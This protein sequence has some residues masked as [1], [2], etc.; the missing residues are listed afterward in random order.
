MPSRTTR[1]PIRAV[2][3]LTGLPV[4]TLRAWE[5]R[6]GAVVPERGERGRVY[7]A[8][9]V[10]RLQLIAS[11]V[12]RGHAIGSIASLPDAELRR[13]A[14]AAA[15]DTPAPSGVDLA[16]L[17][18]AV[19]Q[20]DLPVL[21]SELSRHSLLL[22]PEPLIFGV[23]LP[24]LRELGQRWEAGSINPAQEHLVSA[25]VRGMLGGLL[26]SMPRRA[27]APIVFAAPAGERHE[28]GLLCAAVLA[29][30]S[31]YAPI[32]LGP[33]L[34]A[35]DIA[36]AVRQSRASTL[37][38]AATIE[39]DDADADLG[40]LRQLPSA[41]EVMVGGARAEQLRSAIGSRATPID[42]LEELRRRYQQH[43]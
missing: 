34:P 14:P 7:T 17:L 33:D 26:R 29:A 39:R 38:L 11:L 30:A 37:V 43:G 42:S 20:Y 35:A 23:V 18:R 2:S 12:E 3:R 8:R 28:L 31:G 36:H 13:L 6:Y 16:P 22:P 19:K 27:Q 4:D 21:E 25:I 41:I 32:Y 24:V 10:S 5:R 40:R 9:H 15:A 1:Y